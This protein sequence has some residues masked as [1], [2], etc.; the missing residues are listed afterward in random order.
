MNSTKI[1][2]HSKNEVGVDNGFLLP[3]ILR[4]NNGSSTGGNLCIISTIHN[5]I[6]PLK[7]KAKVILRILCECAL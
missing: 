6:V 3:L 4:E 5:Y 7:I 1:K 2:F